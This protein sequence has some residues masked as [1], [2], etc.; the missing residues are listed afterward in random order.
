MDCTAAS[1]VASALECPI[2]FNTLSDPVV[3]CDNGHLFCLACIT[4]WKTER[5]QDA[6]CPMCKIALFDRPVPVVAVRRIA[7]DFNKYHK[8]IICRKKVRS[9]EMQKHWMDNAVSHWRAT[10][11][12]NVKLKRNIQELQSD[13][14][15][16]KHKMDVLKFMCE[17]GR[18][19]KKISI[20]LSGDSLLNNND[21]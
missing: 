13:M 19:R 18:K 10:A 3:A 12:H 15:E 11:K 1:M 17:A 6:K 14:Q 5:H 4:G 2:C 16:M 21:K 8:C 20:Q 9:D 7:E